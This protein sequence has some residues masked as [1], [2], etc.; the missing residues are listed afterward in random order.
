[1]ETITDTQGRLIVEYDPETGRLVLHAREG[2]EIVAGKTLKLRS[3][4]AIELDAPRVVTR[5]GVVE[6][7][8]DRLHH[9]VS[10]LFHVRAGRIRAEAEKSYVVE[11]GQARLRAEGDVRIDGRTVNLG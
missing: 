4:T 1:M 7:I 9:W 8:V 5:A 11:A 2:L 6:T 10:S 3:D